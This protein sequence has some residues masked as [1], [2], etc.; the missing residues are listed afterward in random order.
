MGLWTWQFLN[1]NV[2]VLSNHYLV[3]TQ[4]NFDII[5]TENDQ[6]MDNNKISKSKQTKS[7][8]NIINKDNNI[9]ANHFY[10][11]N[12]LEEKRKHT[13]SNQILN[14]ENHHYN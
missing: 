14:F 7:N 1:E 13:Y 6:N 10:N 2:K 3:L 8:T 12:T 5:K 4:P 9:N 11:S